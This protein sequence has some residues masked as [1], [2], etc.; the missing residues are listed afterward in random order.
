MTRCAVISDLLQP[1]QERIGELWYEGVIGVAEEHRATSIVDDVLAG[2]AATPSHDPVVGAT[3]IL[4]AL[5]HEQ[6][7]LG[8]RALRLALEDE[9]WV[10][11]YIGAMT[12]ASDLVRMNRFV[13]ADVAL[14]SASYD[15]DLGELAGAVSQLKHQGCRVLVGGAAISGS[16]G[17]WK[18]LGADGHGADARVAQHLARRLCRH[19]QRA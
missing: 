2:L 5:G 1:A 9:G 13:R 11:E 17:L 3:C 14:L 10:C 6:H 18:R 7:V 19:D 12:P 16:A 15:P 4:A 8:L